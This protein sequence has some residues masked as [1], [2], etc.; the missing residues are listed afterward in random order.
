MKMQTNTKNSL[1]GLVKAVVL[2]VTAALTLA[3]G[4]WDCSA[5][6]MSV[7][8]K[9]VSVPVALEKT[10]SSLNLTDGLGLT[11]NTG[12][13]LNVAVTGCASG[14]TYTGTI[15]SVVNLYNGDINCKV[16]LT[17]FILTIGSSTITYSATA[18]GATNFTTWL[19]GDTAT[20]AN[21]T[22]SGAASDL[23]TVYVRNQVT[24]TALTTLDTV[25]YNFTDVQGSTTS[26]A[27]T[28]AI[29]TPVPLTVNGNAAPDFTF[30]DSRIVSTNAN[31]TVNLKLQFQCPTDVTGT[32]PNQSC[33]G[34]SEANMDYL[35]VENTFSNASLSVAQ[36][37]AIFAAGSP[38]AVTQDAVGAAAIGTLSNMTH[39]GI[40]TGSMAT[41]GAPLYPNH[42]NQLFIIRLRNGSGN[43]LSYEYFYVDI[44]S[45]TQS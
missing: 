12:T 27:V 21:T 44:A 2:P 36:V 25:L 9:P 30:Y 39:G 45:L 26:S 43:T 5:T 33:S 11:V 14:Y 24:Q 8:L 18:T 6:T 20:F 42:K 34:L 37:N 19:A 35:L 16:K 10:G 15:T 23:I 32:N 4:L 22:G 40:E 31:G 41:V 38:V 28:D 13:T 1:G 29:S 3:Y 7:A 17:S